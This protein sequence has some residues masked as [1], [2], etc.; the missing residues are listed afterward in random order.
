MNKP[1]IALLLATTAVA[2][3]ALTGASAAYAGS[4]GGGGSK[5]VYRAPDR[6][7]GGG[8]ISL[9][10]KL[11]NR[12]IEVEAEVDTNV[13][14]QTW[15]VTITRGTTV[16]NAIGVTAGLSGSFSVERLISN[17]PGNDVISVAATRLGVTCRNSVIFLG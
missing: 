11:D 6:P 13:I 10:A 14:G 16:I 3:T 8:D 7:C 17:S 5:V 1:R 9:K 4:G 2:A 15:A 12:M